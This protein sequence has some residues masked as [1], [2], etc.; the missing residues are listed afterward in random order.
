MWSG[1]SQFRSHPACV[2]GW[3]VFG[4]VI[5]GHRW[6]CWCPPLSSGSHRCHFRCPVPS[7]G[8]YKERKGHR[9]FLAISVVSSLT[10]WKLFK[11]PRVPLNTYRI[12]I[13]SSPRGSLR[14]FP[15]SFPFLFFFIPFL[16]LSLP[17]LL[18]FSSERRVQALLPLLLS[19][20]VDLWRTRSPPRLC[21]LFFNHRNTTVMSMT[22]ATP[23]PVAT[24]TT[25]HI[26]ALWIK[27]WDLASQ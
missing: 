15:E 25:G 7:S 23:S 16:S 14:L 27:T 11:D 6:S 26:Q 21:L 5:C 13:A 20:T 12:R 8:V 2:A 3:S 9:Q 17:D 10:V 4:L 24:P 1:C 18:L 19:V 22:A